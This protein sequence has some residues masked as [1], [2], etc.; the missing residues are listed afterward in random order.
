MSKEYIKCEE[1]YIKCEAIEQLKLSLIAAGK[2]CRLELANISNEQLIYMAAN[3][4]DPK[5][6]Q[7][8]PAKETIFTSI[9]ET[10]TRY[11]WSG[12]TKQKLFRFIQLTMDSEIEIL[13]ELIDYS[14]IELLILLFNHCEGWQIRSALWQQ[15]TFSSDETTEEVFL[16]YLDD[17]DLLPPL[18]TLFN[19]YI[20]FTVR[21]YKN[22]IEN[23]E[24]EAKNFI[25]M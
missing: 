13:G 17:N 4:I 16:E 24:I 5:S 15:H 12:I 6:S 1:E 11:V 9:E 10:K 25:D 8:D 20:Y 23:I 21:K 7:E 2:V 3:L 14:E 19:D 18:E 22:V